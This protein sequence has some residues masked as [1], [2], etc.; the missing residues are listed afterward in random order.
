MT[1]GINAQKVTLV[2]KSKPPHALCEACVMEKQHRTP[3]RVI[4]RIDLYKQAPQK[5]ELS[6]SDQ[7]GSGKIT[8][9][10]RG[11]RIIFGL[12]DDLT[13]FTEIH[14]LIKKSEAFSWLWKYVAKQK[15]KGN[16]MQR[17]SGDNGCEF[18]SAAFKEWMEIEGI[19]WEPTTPYNPHQNRVAKKCFRTLFERT[20]AM[21]YE[22]GL[23]NN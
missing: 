8:F 3:F 18:H 15:A 22:A 10:S 9:T 11:S 6:H 1:L 19:Q 12:T 23:L 20:Q 21:L 17:F 4:N 16:P 2:K 13:Y 14:L 5:R 7:A